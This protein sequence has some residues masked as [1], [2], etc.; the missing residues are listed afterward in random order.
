MPRLYY[1][2]GH[3]IEMARSMLLLELMNLLT[4]FTFLLNS[5]A[6]DW[7]FMTVSFKFEGRYIDENDLIK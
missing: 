7:V 1:S 3:T 6:I 5:K 4:R 2:I